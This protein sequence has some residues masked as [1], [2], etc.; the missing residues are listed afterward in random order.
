MEVEA[1]SEF[2]IVIVSPDKVVFEGKATR[3]TVPGTEQELAILPDHT[4]LY[5]ELK[6]GEVVINLTGGKTETVPITSGVMR[7]KQNK[8]SIILGFSD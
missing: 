5:A 1:S 7:V 2:N 4:P 6:K 3:V 8:V